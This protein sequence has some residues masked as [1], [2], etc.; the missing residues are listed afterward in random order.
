MLV[1]KDGGLSSPEEGPE[2]LTH[3]YRWLFIISSIITVVWGV[4]GLFMLPDLPNRPNPRAIWFTRNHAKLAMERLARYGREEPKKV[5][6]S[7]IK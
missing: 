6:W 2:V 7:G 3:V 5:S 4:A 1:S